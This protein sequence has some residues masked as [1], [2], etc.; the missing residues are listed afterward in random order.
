[1][2]E[3]ISFKPRL[4]SGL[5]VKL[6]RFDEI[7]YNGPLSEQEKNA[8][9]AINQ[10]CKKAKVV[11]YCS[12]QRYARFL[13]DIMTNAEYESQQLIQKISTLSQGEFCIDGTNIRPVRIVELN[14]IK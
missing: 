3:Y 12:P 7:Q 6:G 14:R 2:I 4:V 1:M 5:G 11:L 8:I 13:D 9:D 10:A